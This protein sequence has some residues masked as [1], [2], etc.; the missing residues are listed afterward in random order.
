MSHVSARRGTFYVSVAA[1][2]WGTG[3]AAGSLLFQSGGLGSVDVSFWRYLL[4]AAFLYAT[5]CLRSALTSTTVRP[6]A[7]TNDLTSSGG[8]GGGWRQRSLLGR[9]GRGRGSL[10]GRVDRRVLV[11]G[12]GMA[13]Y[14]TAYFG[15]IAQSGVAVA[16]VV[17]MGATPVFTALGSRFLL[18]EHLGRPALAALATALGGLFLLT[19]ESAVSAGDV[20]AGRPAGIAL[21]LVSAAGYAA[22][23]LYSRRH[24]D[25]PQ[26]TAMGGFAVAAAC[27][28]PFA[29][30]G[31]V[32]PE[33]GVTPVALL[34]YLGAVPTALAYALFFRAL[35]ALNATTVSIISLGEA[36]GAA[37]LGVVLFG[38]RLAPLAWCGCALLLAA[39]LVLAVQAGHMADKD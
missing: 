2:A 22:V 28:A 20:G 12:V 35:T 13:V 4:G 19:G 23:T 32:L 14:Q 24:H 9:V 36:V 30:A 7:A 27:L 21:A 11:V 6:T 17:T 34:L 25:D 39:V 26:R 8:V 31:G 38:E 10:S 29:L 5:A 18:R 3:G 16:T 1:T 37:V 33:A 15:A